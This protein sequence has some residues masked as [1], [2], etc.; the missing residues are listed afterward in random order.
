MNYQIQLNKK[1]LFI[2]LIILKFIRNMWRN[3][4][5]RMRIIL[6]GTYEEKEVTNIFAKIKARQM[7]EFTDLSSYN[8][9]VKKKCR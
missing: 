4:Q 8:D 6:K 1:L 7:V 9:S 2:D 3:I 5:T